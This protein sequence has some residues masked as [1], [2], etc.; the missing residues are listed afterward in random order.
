MSV[1]VSHAQEPQ[2]LQNI[3]CLAL[4]NVLYTVPTPA[5]VGLYAP[6]GRCKILLL[7]KIKEFMVNEEFQQT[8]KT[9]CWASGLNLLK[10]LFLMIFYRPVL[11]GQQKWRRNVK[12]V[13]IH[14]SAWEYAGSD[15]L[16]AGLI[17]T[18]CDHIERHFG[19]L[20]MSVFRAV[21]KKSGIIEGP[22]DQEWVIKK[23]LFLPLWATVIFLSVVAIGMGV[24]L[25][26]LGMHIGDASRDAIA[27]VEGIGVM[28][29]GL[30]AVTAIKFTFPVVRNIIVT[31]KCQ[32]ERQMNRTDLS[33]QL[34]FMSSVKKEVRTITRFLQFMEIFQRQK[35]RVVLE[36]THLDRCSP[37]RVVGVLNAMNILL[38]D[39]DAPFIS[40]LAVDPS[41]IVDCVESSTCVKGMANNGYKFL[42]RIVTLPFCVPQMD[43]DTK[44]GLIRDIIDRRKPQVKEL[45]VKKANPYFL[46]NPHYDPATHDAMNPVTD[47]SCTPLLPDVRTQQS[48]TGSYGKDI[49]T[50]ELIQ[51][52]D[53]LLDESLKEFMPDNMVQMQRIVNTITITIT[54][55]KSNLFKDTVC[56]KKV[57]EW[58]LLA[59]QW[60]CRLSWL[61]QCIEDEK[62]RSRMGSCQESPLRPDMS[63][64]EVYEKYMEELDKLKGQMEKL[65]ELDQDPE[66]FSLLCRKFRVE[67]AN[68]YLP[69]TVNLDLSLKRHMELQ[70]GSHSLK[71]TKTITS[72]V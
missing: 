15:Q 55:L 46:S 41:I 39:N 66:L 38:S 13:F 50:K 54:L 49:R 6:W 29:I 43:C 14:F 11:T 1:M 4:A 21:G 2:T 28:A 37:D 48:E 69:F 3:Y 33:A 60:P 68:S 17:T 65:L 24:F 63:L 10:L 23:F 22:G 44:N 51:A 67:E 61:L 9:Q 36:I 58:V 53:H 35:L 25:L 42:N 71:Q 64:C 34:G 7:K 62:Q 12:H 18:L 19:L 32:L 40:I 27:V 70:R 72:S 31:Q 20:P 56:P 45:E 47:D 5:I 52:F 26:V 59:N 30:S 57:V 16:W 8:Q